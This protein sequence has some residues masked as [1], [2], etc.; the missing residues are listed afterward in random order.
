MFT[1]IK[2]VIQN[3]F[4]KSFTLKYPKEKAN[5]S[6]N[7]RGTIHVDQK[8]C[9]ACKLCEINCPTGAIIVDPKK[10]YS[11]V[12]RDLCI[13]CGLCAEVCPVNVIWFSNNCENAEKKRTEFAKQLPG[14]NPRPGKRS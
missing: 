2:K 9:I 1:M 4:F 10:K 8:K 13:L 14:P 7:F 3:I 6:I 11:V 5:V 12:D